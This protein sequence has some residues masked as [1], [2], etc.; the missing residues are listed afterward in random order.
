VKSKETDMLKFQNGI[1][2][3]VAWLLIQNTFQIEMKQSNEKRNDD[4][5]HEQEG[6]DQLL[7]LFIF[8][9]LINQSSQYLTL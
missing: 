9:A 6:T 7:Q 2:L 1:K 5:G 8:L 4:K 3:V